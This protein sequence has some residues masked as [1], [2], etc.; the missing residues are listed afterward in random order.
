MMSVFNI[1]FF[2]GGEIFKFFFQCGYAIVLECLVLLLRERER[3]RKKRE[4]VDRGERINLFF[5]LF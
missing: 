2:E 5:V 1:F 3:E 4:N